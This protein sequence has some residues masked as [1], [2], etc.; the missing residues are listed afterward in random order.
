[1]PCTKKCQKKCC[2]SNAI[3]PIRAYAHLIYSSTVEQRINTFPNDTFRGV[4]EFNLNPVAKNII[5]PVD[6]DISKFKVTVGG[7][8]RCSWILNTL[9]TR[10]DFY[11]LSQGAFTLQINGKILEDR[12]QHFGYYRSVL[13]PV[14]LL[15]IPRP[16]LVGQDMLRLN[17][18]DVV[19]LRLRKSDIDLSVP[20]DGLFVILTANGF[21][22]NDPVAKT[23]N[24]VGADLI[25]ERV[26][27]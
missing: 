26:D 15:P 21:N 16:Q 8:Y 1:M 25:F 17:S 27:F 14:P 24:C 23:F 18:G 11:Y 5:H 22:P 12:P 10:G 7:V 20:D 19:Q 3:V 4:V 6:G 13:P 9:S 2:C